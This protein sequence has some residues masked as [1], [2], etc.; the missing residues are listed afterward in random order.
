MLDREV[1]IILGVSG[2]V[3]LERAH[4]LGEMAKMAEEAKCPETATY[5]QMQKER[6]LET[7]TEMIKACEAKKG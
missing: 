6:V 1:H 2:P 3:Y 5:L 4:W 7:V